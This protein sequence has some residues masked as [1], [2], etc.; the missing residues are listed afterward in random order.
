MPCCVIPVDSI[1]AVRYPSSVRKKA[2]EERVIRR[3]ANRK[4][5]DAR[6]RRYVTLED[7]GRMVEAGEQVSVLEQSNG[8]DISTVVLAQVVLEGIK[9]KTARIPRVA[10]EGL[11]RWGEPLKGALVESQMASSRARDEVQRIVGDLLGRGRIN[12]EEAMT[13]RQEVAEAVQRIVREAQQGLEHVVQGLLSV[14]PHKKAR[15]T[16]VAKRAV[17]VAR[18]SKPSK[19]KSKKR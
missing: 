16:P 3:Y 17:K 19:S 6:T 9:Q 4:L 13:L 8:N 10:L 14:A 15:N 12:L 11:I 5:Y 18:K 7:L 2:T 1:D